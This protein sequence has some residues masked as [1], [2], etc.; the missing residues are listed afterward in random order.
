MCRSPF[1][2]TGF[3]DERRHGVS[4]SI[5]GD[6]LRGDGLDRCACRA[7]VAKVAGGE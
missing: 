3:L 7:L 1:V 6:G 2:R 4:M 5:A